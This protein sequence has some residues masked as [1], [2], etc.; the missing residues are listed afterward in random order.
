[1]SNIIKWSNFKFSIRL[2]FSKRL[3]MKLTMKGQKVF[4]G[5][6][7]RFFRQLEREHW[8]S[9][10]CCQ[11]QQHQHIAWWQHTPAPSLPHT[12]ACALTERAN[13]CVCMSESVS[14][15]I[16][17]PVDRARGQR[18]P[19]WRVPL[20]GSSAAPSHWFH[21]GTADTG[22]KTGGGGGKGRRDTG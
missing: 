16:P 5:D 21:E 10:F 8:G 12:H 22:R 9:G 19:N 7:Q 2:N 18:V 1:M 3:L 11:G 6:K 4:V 17:P 20:L 13:E 15:S 14:E